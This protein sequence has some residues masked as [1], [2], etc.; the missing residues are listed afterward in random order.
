AQTQNVTISCQ[1]GCYYCCSAYVEASIQE[2]ETIVYYLYQHDDLFKNYLKKYPKWREEIRNNGDLFKE[3]GKFWRIEVTPE[4]AANLKKQSDDENRRY[5]KQNIMCPFLDNGLC[6]IY[7]VRPYM[8]VSLT[9]VSLREYC[10]PESTNRP[11]TIRAFKKELL[12]DRSFYYGKFQ[13]P[14]VTCM[15]IA[16]YEILKTGT[17]YYSGAGVPGLDNLDREFCSDPDVLLRLRK[18]GV[19]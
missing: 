8:C 12:M 7:E 17:Y 18:H 2:C 5:Y 10:K 19:I 9:S 3:C 6:S 4:N 16:V 1:K 15:Q 11:K 14:I 13:S